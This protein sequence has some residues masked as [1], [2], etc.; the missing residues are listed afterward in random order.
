MH[1]YLSKLSILL[2]ATQ[3]LPLLKSGGSL[4]HELQVHPLPHV[5]RAHVMVVDAKLEAGL[6]ECRPQEVQL[7]VVYSGEEVVQRVVAKGGDH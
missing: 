4:S 7:G 2:G 5:H 6:G 3:G 1:G